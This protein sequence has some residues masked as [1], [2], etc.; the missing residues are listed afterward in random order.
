MRVILA[1]HVYHSLNYR[2]SSVKGLIFVLY[3]VKHRQRYE[4]LCLLDSQPECC[5]LLILQLSSCRQVMQQFVCLCLVS[6]HSIR[7]LIFCHWIIIESELKPKHYIIILSLPP[8]IGGRRNDS[9]QILG[10][11]A[12]LH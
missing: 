8:T 9:C 6:I 11:E 1:H 3:R 5:A 12:F 4:F 7:V 2:W 10:F